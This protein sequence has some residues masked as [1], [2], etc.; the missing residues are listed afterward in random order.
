MGM[1][2]RAQLDEADRS[3]NFLVDTGAAYSVLTSYSRAFSSQICT[4]LGAPGKKQLQ[5]D[6]L[7]HFFVA[8]MDKYFPASFWQSLSVLLPYWKEIYTLNWSAPL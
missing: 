2:P 3:E 7:E 6:S 1:E 4:S 8:G 5:K